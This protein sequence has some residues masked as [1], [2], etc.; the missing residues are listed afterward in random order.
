MG[1][2]SLPV[3]VFI[4][5]VLA[6]VPVLLL[7]IGAEVLSRTL[8]STLSAGLVSIG[9]LV[10]VLGWCLVLAVV[11]VRSLSSEASGM[12]TL[13][14]RGGTAPTD[15]PESSG[16]AVGQLATAL[17]ERNRQ[18]ATLAAD[19][20][21]A[22]ITGDPRDVAAHIVSSARRLTGDPTWVLAVVR[23]NAP[24]L[25]SSGVYHAESS[26]PI[27]EIGESERWASTA[28]APGMPQARASKIDGPWG[29][30]LVVDVVTGG[31]LVAMLTAPWE[32]RPQP[33]TAD[34]DLLSLLAQHAG[35][36][37]EHALLYATVRQQAE[38]LDRMAGI[39]SDFLRGVSHDLQTPLTSIRALAV[40][41]QAEAGI[42]ETARDDLDVIS[43]QADRLRRMVTQLLVVSR[44]EAG[45]LTPRQEILA[46]RPLVERTWRALRADRPFSIETSGSAQLVVADPDRLEQVLW[47]LLDNAAKYSHPGAPISVR[48]Q[49]AGAETM[50][51]RISDEGTGMDSSSLSHAFEQFYRADHARKLV[52]DGSGVGLY[53]ARGLVKAMGGEIAIESTLGRGTTVAITLPAEHAGAEVDPSTPAPG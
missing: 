47:A 39:Q 52:P 7:G 6:V 3:R 27:A 12:I 11:Y 33:S 44:L 41:L 51:V 37:L 30:F 34:R 35:T 40:E 24:E 2:A 53:A 36:Q 16:N 5:L 23:T 14:R 46:V 18:V 26:D 48:I 50:E 4:G 13:A 28:E 9:L 15:G 45:V 1:R 17:E 43:H 21:S 42:S 25:L 32:G 31:D 38:A 19:M 22:P 29:A 49:P 10:V 20:K 8:L